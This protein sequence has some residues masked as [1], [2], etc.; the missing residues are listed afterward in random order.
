MVPVPFLLISLYSEDKSAINADYT[1]MNKGRS[2]LTRKAG[3][4]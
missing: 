1:K 2:K 3:K 4:R